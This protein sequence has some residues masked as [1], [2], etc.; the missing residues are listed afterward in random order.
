MTSSVQAGFVANMQDVAPR[1]AGILF[2]LANTAGCAAG[3]LGTTLVG[4]MIKQTHSWSTVFQL[5]TALYVVGTICW[6]ALCS[7]DTLFPLVPT[8]TM[9]QNDD[10][11]D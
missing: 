7:G 5:M 9:K 6:L 2:G 1:Y 3:I 4:F 10:N 11:T 8:T